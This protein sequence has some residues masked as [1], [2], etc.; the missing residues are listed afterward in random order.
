PVVAQGQ[1]LRQCRIEHPIP[2][3][4][5]ERGGHIAA[6]SLLLATELLAIN[7]QLPAKALL[8][9]VSAGTP[10]ALALAVQGAGVI[11]AD[12]CHGDATGQLPALTIG[13]I[14]EL[15]IAFR[16]T[17]LGPPARP[18][19]MG[20]YVHSGIVIYLQRLHDDI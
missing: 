7:L 9:R 11:V 18:A 1:R 16:H 20:S 10:I 17:R 2:P 13:S 19:M 3:L 8:R 15:H 4:P 12:V 5:G 6:R 14:T